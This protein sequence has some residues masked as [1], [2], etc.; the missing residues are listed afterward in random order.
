MG[1]LCQQ[2]PLI[3]WE[4]A[5]QWDQIAY[6]YKPENGAQM[7]PTS[8]INLG[9]FAFALKVYGDHMES[10]VGI[11]FPEG[12]II[13]ADPD[14]IA[15]PDSFVVVRINKDRGATL[16]RLI[17]QGNK[18]YLKPLNR[19]YPILEFTFNTTILGIVKQLVFNF[20]RSEQKKN[21]QNYPNT[22]HE[23]KLQHENSIKA[24]EYS[25]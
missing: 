19:R 7:I 16:K 3:S 8:A 12:S 9:P 4:E 5:K 20:N 24:P 11:S 17:V 2:V 22:Q 14:T 23:D 6:K 13:I 25:G 10:P 15:I 1:V 21:L 18:R